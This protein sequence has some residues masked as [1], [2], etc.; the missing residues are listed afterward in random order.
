MPRPRKPRLEV[1]VD[2]PNLERRELWEGVAESLRAAIV[3]GKIPAGSSLVEADLAALFDV[4][5]GP[6]RDA[7]RDLAREGLVVDLPRRGTI[8]STLTFSD[9]RDVYAVR[10][11]LEAVG[12]RL[13]IERAS[14]ADLERLRAA[15][16]AM[17]TAWDR[18]IDYAESLLIDLAFHRELVGLS[19]NPRLIPLYEQMLSQT[20]L[21]VHNA[22]V[23]NPRLRHGL[24]RSAHR[25]IVDAVA[26]RD[27]EGARRAI[28]EHYEYAEERLF[29]RAKVAFPADLET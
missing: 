10:E 16:V 12:A 18:R 6:V 15:V 8:V 4:S 24:K 17:E 27:V 11:G 25:E 9:T 22:V 19:T 29:G 20:Q 2:P 7:L 1:G 23:V 28:A 14:D 13:A 21:L 26:R 5:R 3:S